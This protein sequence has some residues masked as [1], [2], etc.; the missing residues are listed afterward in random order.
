MAVD[1]RLFLFLKKFAGDVLLTMN[2]NV[3]PVLS[4]L[5]PDE[6][7][8]HFYGRFFLDLRRN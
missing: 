4:Y 3:F 5:F 1:S 8:L 2:H 6:F 7:F